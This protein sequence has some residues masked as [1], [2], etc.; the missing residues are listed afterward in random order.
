MP[1]DFYVVRKNLTSPNQDLHAADVS[2]TGPK[3]FRPDRN[4][5]GRDEERLEILNPVFTLVGNVYEAPHP[6]RYVYRKIK[7]RRAGAVLTPR[8][9]VNTMLFTTYYTR[10]TRVCYEQIISDSR[11]Y[12]FR[13]R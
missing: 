8:T 3:L 4:V 10:A 7:L 13:L 6:Y 11:C 9:C 2:A 5:A 1:G 12:T